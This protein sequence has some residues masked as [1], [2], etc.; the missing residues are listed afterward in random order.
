M[1]LCT[2][3]YILLGSIALGMMCSGLYSKPAKEG[4]EY[5]SLNL[6]IARLQKKGL[7]IADLQ[8]RLDGLSSRGLPCFEEP[9]CKNLWIEIGSEGAQHQILSTLT[10]NTSNPK[11]TIRYQSLADRLMRGRDVRTM[12]HPTKCV[13]PRQNSIRA[14]KGADF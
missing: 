6:A 13:V 5:G 12:K 8:K 11:A 3:R 4:R 14:Q 10:V 7:P 1:R 9:D 2:W